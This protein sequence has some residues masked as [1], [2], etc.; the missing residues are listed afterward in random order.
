MTAAI[1]LARETLSQFQRHNAQWLAA[2]IAYFTIFAVAPLIM[3]VV[4]IA[5]F[6]LGAHQ[7]LLSRLYDYISATAGPSAARG[8]EAVVATAFSSRKAGIFSQSVGW[9]VFVIAAVGLFSALQQALNIV[10]DVGSEKRTFA[11]TVKQRLL[12]FVAVL[13][14]ALLLAVSVGVSAL[15][16]IAQTSL[17][18]ELPGFVTIA[19][20]LDFIASWLV[21]AALFAML[22]E[23]LPDC[24][25][26][27]R[28]VWL[29]AAIS[30]LLFVLGQIF[31]G[32]YLAR[33]GIATAYGAYGGLIIF[34]VWANYSAQIVLLGAEFTHVYARRL[35]SR[36]GV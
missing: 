23:F 24:R 20:G 32:W 33:A 9:S 27:W 18:H 11:E 26:A 19:K 31:L 25:I 16:T 21:A 3:V 6:F 8:I 2:A 35:G 34:I 10:W 29:G 14:I 1:A 30:A 28:D 13:G 12:S 7:P 22:Y 5:G 15:L 17:A 36:R 4:E